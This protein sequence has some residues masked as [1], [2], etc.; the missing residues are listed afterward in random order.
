MW[1][2]PDPCQRYLSTSNENG[3][4]DSKC[5]STREPVTYRSTSVDSTELVCHDPGPWAVTT[6]GKCQARIIF[7]PNPL[8]WAMSDVRISFAATSRD[9]IRVNSAPAFGLLNDGPPITATSP[10]FAPNVRGAEIPQTLHIPH[11]TICKELQL[12]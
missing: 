12:Q 2:P 8:L 11:R 5:S 3:N 9:P 1:F 10:Y 7:G 6:T 4:E